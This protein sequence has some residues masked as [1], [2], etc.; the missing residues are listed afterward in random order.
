MNASEALKEIKGRELENIARNGQCV[1][2]IVL[3]SAERDLLVE[4]AREGL[5]K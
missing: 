1:R 4:L 3:T 5:R 2:A